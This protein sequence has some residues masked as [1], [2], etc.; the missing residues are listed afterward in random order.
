[1]KKKISLQLSDVIVEKLKAAAEE[2]GVNRAII[3]EKAL[4][5]FLSET[6]GDTTPSGGGEQIGDQLKSI[7]RELKAINET[8]ALHARYHLAVTT[9]TQQGRGEPSLTGSLEAITARGA[10]ELDRATP[11]APADHK[12]RQQAAGCGD[13]IDAAEMNRSFGA[14]VRRNDRRPW[15]TSVPEVAWGL[16]GAAQEG[17]AEDYFRGPQQEPLR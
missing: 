15:A 16:P 11:V 2:R 3:V 17:G 10:T 4:A 6:I 12:G 7:Q 1:M 9:L 14:P 5:R 13:V 8:V